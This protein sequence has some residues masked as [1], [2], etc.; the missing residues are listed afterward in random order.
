MISKEKE[1]VPFDKPMQAAGRWHAFSLLSVTCAL[2]STAPCPSYLM[3]SSQLSVPA[4]KLAC[5]TLVGTQHHQEML[6]CLNRGTKHALGNS[7]LRS[8]CWLP[9]PVEH[10][11]NEVEQRMK[12]SVR[13]QIMASMADYAVRPRPQWVRNWPAM[14]V[15]AVSAIFWSQVRLSILLQ[16]LQTSS[17]L[18]GLIL[19][20]HCRH[21]PL[22]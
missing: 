17:E 13:A 3:P 6:V 18:P 2:L 7:S 5:G 15:L 4:T 11:L 16:G 1:R 21:V 14:V 12:A 9:G 10:W 8:V 20:C 22:Q 19:I